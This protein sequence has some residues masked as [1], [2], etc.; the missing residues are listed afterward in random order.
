MTIPWA[1]TVHIKE[2]WI[3]SVPV[4]RRN[5]IV[6]RYNHRV[7]GETLLFDT[8][9]EEVPWTVISCVGAYHSRRFTVVPGRKR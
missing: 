3:R 2:I 7:F 5:H 9:N 4:S 6:P 1:T 8:G